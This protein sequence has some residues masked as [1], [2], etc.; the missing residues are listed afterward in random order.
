MYLTI[1][2]FSSVNQKLRLEKL[3]REAGVDKQKEEKEVGESRMSHNVE[4]CPFRAQV[5][6]GAVVLTKINRL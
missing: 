3:M 6:F 4:S 1:F 5:S 2:L